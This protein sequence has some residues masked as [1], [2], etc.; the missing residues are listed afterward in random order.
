[1]PNREVDNAAHLKSQSQHGLSRFRF[2]SIGVVSANQVLGSDQ[3][4]V[5]AIEDYPFLHGELTDNADEL[6]VSGVDASGAAFNSK[7]ITTNS[8]PAT[9]LKNHDN[10]LTAPNVRRGE[11][12]ILYQFGNYNKFYWTTQQID[13]KLRRLETVIY[14]WSGAPEEDTPPG[15]DNMYYLEISTHAGH[16]T[17]HTSKANKEPFAYDLQINTKEGYVLVRDD[18]GNTFSIDSKAHRVEMTNTDGCHYDMHQKNLTVTVPESMTF[19]S[20]N[21]NLVVDQALRVSAGESATLMT[22]ALSQTAQSSTL[23]AQTIANTASGSFSAQ[24]AGSMNLQA[25]GPAS[26]SSSASATIASPA[27]TLL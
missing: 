12:V 11:K 13:M 25:G 27:T 5:V 7:L 2:Y 17:F 3:I 26:L 18:I 1:M 4:E 19:I 22:K 14:G 21:M 10:R 9:W 23:S 8:I 6:T 15:P 16:V 24:A 20:K